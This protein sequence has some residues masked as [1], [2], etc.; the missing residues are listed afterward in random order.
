MENKQQ[1]EVK[2]EPTEK[3]FIFIKQ[4][5]EVA[6]AEESETKRTIKP[7]IKI[8]EYNSPSELFQ[9]GETEMQNNQRMLQQKVYLKNKGEM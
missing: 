9:Q 7:C 3:G 2:E 8:I 1:L 6:Q 4:N 5:E